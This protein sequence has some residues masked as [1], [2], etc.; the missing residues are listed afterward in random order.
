MNKWFAYQYIRKSKINRDK[1]MLVITPQKLIENKLEGNYT[2]DDNVVV[3]ITCYRHN[4]TCI[5]IKQ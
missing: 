5:T 2:I 1:V 3:V 4:Y